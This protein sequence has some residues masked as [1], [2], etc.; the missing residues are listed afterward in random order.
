MNKVTLIG[1]LGKDP[2]VRQTNNGTTVV[3]LALATKGKKKDQAGNWVDKTEWHRVVG[4][5]KRI[6]AI[7][8]YFKKGSGIVIEG[9]LETRQWD[10][11]QGQKR[12]TTEVVI[13]DWEFP[14][15]GSGQGRSSGSNS[16]GDYQQDQSN[17]Y[18]DHNSSS[19]DDDD[20]PF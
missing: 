4:F 17:D 9:E 18:G 13:R 14:P 5:G 3:N 1:N 20:I 2:E 16:Q 7:G 6:E 11:K 12:Y 8:K 10:D 19:I 15:A